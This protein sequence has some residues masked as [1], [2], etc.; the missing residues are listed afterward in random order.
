MIKLFLSDLD[1]TLTDSCYYVFGDGSPSAK[2][3]NTKDF[4]GF[5]MLD[6]AGVSCAVLTS[7]RDKCNEAQFNRSCSRALLHQ[8]VMD[9]FGFVLETFVDSGQYKWKEIAFIGDDLNDLKLLDHVGLSGCP[10][11]AVIEVKKNVNWESNLRGGD[12]C[13][14]DFA[15]LVLTEN[16]QLDHN[17]WCIID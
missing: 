11:D 13:V 15:R 5:Y 16:G 12:G 8:R 4:M 1:G 9:K 3:F 14:R 10:S 7:S 6:K 17:A 2:R